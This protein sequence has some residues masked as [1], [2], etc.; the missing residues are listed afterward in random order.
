VQ[1]FRDIRDEEYSASKCNDVVEDNGLK[2]L[3][4]N[5]LEVLEK[6]VD[7]GVGKNAKN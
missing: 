2:D 6:P 7:C 3:R 5:A 1:G 4:F